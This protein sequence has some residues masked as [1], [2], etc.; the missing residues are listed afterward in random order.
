MISKLKYPRNRV[1]KHG[2]ALPQAR[3][4]DDKEEHGLTL[5]RELKAS[6]WFDDGRDE[7]GR[8]TIRTMVDSQIERAHRTGRINDRQ[9]TAA[10]KFKMHY[11]L[12]G[13]AGQITSLD[14]NCVF[15]TDPNGF[16]HLAGTISC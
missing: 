4:R 14:L 2:G 12:A 7:R 1:R 9:F 5:E 13:M 10:M 8:P 16:A 3:P 6:G 15:G 11:Q